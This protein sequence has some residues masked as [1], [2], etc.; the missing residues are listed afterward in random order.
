VAA[1]VYDTDLALASACVA[2]D[3]AAIAALDAILRAQAKRAVKSLGQPT[4][5]EDE[6]LQAVRQHLL[7]AKDGVPPRLATFSGQSPLDRWLRVVVTHSALDLLRK[8]GRERGD[9]DSRLSRLPAPAGDPELDY[10]RRR[11]RPEFEAAVREA[12]ATITDAR[13]RNLLRLHVLD[14]VGV[15]RLGE[16]YQVNASTA[17]RWIARL[18]AHLHREVRRCLKARL[19]LTE[20]ELRSLIRLVKSDLDVTLS[21]LLNGSAEF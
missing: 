17:S 1:P 20:S 5:L 2:G 10:L 12:F 15:E 4:W 18:R 6:V 21:R 13:D 19:R 14:R 9:G 3:A 11:Y 16:I 7:V 8:Q